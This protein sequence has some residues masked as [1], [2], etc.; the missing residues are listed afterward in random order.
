M[1][2]KA[3]VKNFGFESSFLR[4][5]ASDKTNHQFERRINLVIYFIVAT[6]S[7]LGSSAEF[8]KK[9]MIFCLTV[10]DGH[11]I[12]YSNGFK[13]RLWFSRTMLLGP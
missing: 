1:K 11:A 10:C 13:H 4:L 9:H 7:R 2:S 12:C 3:I 5:V 8:I 6:H